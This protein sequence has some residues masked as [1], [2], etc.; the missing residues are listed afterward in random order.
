MPD[1]RIKFEH[2]DIRNVAWYDHH[3]GQDL[4]LLNVHELFYQESTQRPLHNYV[5]IYNRQLRQQVSF[6]GRNLFHLRELP[7]HRLETMQPVVCS[8][9]R[10]RMQT[11]TTKY[12]L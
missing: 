9:G 10:E 3:L 7:E 4:L 6:L 2:G 1:E 11:M 5:V 8:D 12:F